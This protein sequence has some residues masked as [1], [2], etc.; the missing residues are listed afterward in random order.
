MD[1]I[2]DRC[3]GLDVHKRSVMAAV[4]TPKPGGGRR[5]HVKEFSTFTADLV[6]LRDWLVA[7]GDRGGHGG[8]RRLLAASVA[9]AGGGGR[10]R[11][12]AGQPP[13]RQE[14]A[15]AQDRRGNRESAGKRRSGRARKGNAVLRSAMCEAA[16]AAS[17]TADTYLAAQYRRFKRRF[18][19]K[20]EGKAIF[21]TWCASSSVS[22]T[23][24]PSSPRPERRQPRM[25][26]GASPRRTLARATP[27]VN[28]REFRSGRCG[29]SAGSSTSG[30]ALAD[31]RRLSVRLGHH[32]PLPM[33][34]R[35]K[36]EVAVARGVGMRRE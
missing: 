30:A 28:S 8:D 9:R 29:G 10:L 11:A 19:T 22:E 27:P 12:A 15:R 21:A 17:H 33:R 23:R 26:V 31:R 1:V 16:W 20:S 5:Q 25:F 35:R 6:M 14:R 18:G 32:P 4:R 36:C 13:P 34:V 2:V 3:A 7:E 24:S